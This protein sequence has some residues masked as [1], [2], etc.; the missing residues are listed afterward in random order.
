MLATPTR[1]LLA[2][3]R[4]L[5]IALAALGPPL[6]VQ[7][8]PRRFVI[9]RGA[10]LPAMYGGAE[11]DE[12][13][14]DDEEDGD[15]DDARGD[16]DDTGDGDEDD[17]RAGDARGDDED[18]DDLDEDELP[19]RVKR[20][21][22]K[23]RRARRKLERENRRFKRDAAKARRTTSTGRRDDDR[24]ADEDGKP[25]AGTENLQKANLLLALVDKGYRGSQARLVSRLLDD[26]EF[27]DN[28]QPANL[29][30]VL[31]EAQEVYGDALGRPAKPKAPKTDGGAGP[32][33]TGKPAALTADELKVARACGMSAEE[34]R[35]YKDPQHRPAAKKAG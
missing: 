12:E 6:T 14:A 15:D 11:D 8:G 5:L 30:D 26:V 10:M 33:Q 19:E 21:L 27:D 1:A 3:I 16:D 31:E 9:G 17:D 24:P 29:D 13:D 32:K 35:A 20:A 18:D 2:R 22:R 34:Y 23:E 4:S 25:D 28:N 7:V